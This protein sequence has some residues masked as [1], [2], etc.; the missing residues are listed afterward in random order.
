[1]TDLDLWHADEQRYQREAI[2]LPEKPVEGEE[3]KT[4]P[5]MFVKGKNQVQEKPMAWTTFRNFYV[6]RFHN[7]LLDVSQNEPN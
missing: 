4:L 3:P 6:M 1:M 2:G 7:P 5:G